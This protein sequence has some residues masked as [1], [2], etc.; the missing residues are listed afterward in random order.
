MWGV[1]EVEAIAVLVGRRDRNVY[2]ADPCTA[3][4][5]WPVTAIKLCVPKYYLRCLLIRT[6]F[7][8]YYLKCLILYVLKGMHSGPRI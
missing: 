5:E 6:N 3:I 4:S 8:Y 7:T 2:R 1:V